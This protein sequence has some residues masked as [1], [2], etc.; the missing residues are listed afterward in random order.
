MSHRVIADVA[1][2]YRRCLDVISTMSHRVIADVSK[3]YRRC[4]FKLQTVFICLSHFSFIY[5]AG[6]Q[7]I[8]ELPPGETLFSPVEN[9]K[10][11]VDFG[12][13]KL[14]FMELG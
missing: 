3:Q 8:T 9:K 1:S 7:G 6:Q 5:A 11:R 4:L 2:Q 14:T 12:N 13:S 10:A